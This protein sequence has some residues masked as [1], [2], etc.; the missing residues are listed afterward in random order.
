MPIGA[1]EAPLRLSAMEF[2]GRL[3]GGWSRPLIMV[4]RDAALKKYR[5]ALKVRTP[6]L[7]YGRGHR[8]A[9]SLACELICAVLARALGFRVP[10]YY[11]IDIPAG[12]DATVGDPVVQQIL[13]DNVG[14]NFATEFLDGSFTWNPE[15]IGQQ[16]PELD[17]L[18]DILSFDASVFNEDRTHGKTNLLWHRGELVLID[19]SLAL[20]VHTLPLPDLRSCGPYPTE[21]I[22]R[23]CSFR[24]LRGKGRSFSRVGDRW[25]ATISDSD[26]ASVIGMVPPSWQH[27]AG[28]LENLRVFLTLQASRHGYTSSNLRATVQ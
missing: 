6:E 9:T 2:Q 16:S 8:G 24:P 3:D 17:E 5:V 20:H 25:Q 22:R 26:L 7:P 4:A 1:T 18:E 10:Q 19:H 11:I 13:R 23:H 15:T 28:H 14:E 21:A 12:L 27:A